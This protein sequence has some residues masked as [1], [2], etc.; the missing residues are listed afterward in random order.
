[1]ST[2]GDLAKEGLLEF[3]DGYRTR[4]DEH[5]LEGFRILRAGDV[6]DG[7]IHPD[8]PDFV[9]SSFA[10][11]IGA[12]AAREGDVVLT[13]K[14]TV[15]RV[16][17]VAT[18]ES[19]VV[20]S[21]QVCFFRSTRPDILDLRFL[22]QWLSSPNF[23]D[24]AGYLKSATDM[25]PYISL[26][27]LASTRIELPPIPTQRAIAE[28]LGALDDKIAANSDLRRVSR[29]LRAM[30]FK[31]AL[32]Q[33]RE[34]VP[35]ATLTSLLSR[36]KAP[37]YVDTEDAVWVINQKCVRNGAVSLSSARFADRLRDPRLSAGDVLV[38]S[39]GQGTLGR[40]GVWRDEVPAFAD[41]HVTVVRFDPQLIDP[42]VGAEALLALEPE[43][44]SMGEGSTGQTELSRKA[45]AALEVRL[46]P[47]DSYRALGSRLL[48]LHRREHQASEESAHLAELRDTLL[49]HLMSG[50]LTVR[51]AEKQV[52]VAL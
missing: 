18:L 22:Y 5:A 31:A 16:A 28:V 20:Y 41:S 25:A 4:R 24:Q 15:G 26:K 13:T 46:P 37:K 48:A 3:S 42:W 33:R 44:A 8:G 12:K 38:N 2:L 14:G 11:A 17:F 10:S 32:A 45:L 21:P 39:T 43:I 36:G 6:R 19:A 1:M 52:E 23:V 51:E 9:D 7:Q 35:L 40:V 27:D 49:P 47:S 50:R 34:A 29:E 30:S